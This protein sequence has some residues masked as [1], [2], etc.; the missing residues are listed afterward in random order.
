MTMAEVLERAHVAVRER[1]RLLIGVVNAAKVVKM[2]KDELL[3]GSLLE[4]DVLL[5]DGQ[6]VVWASR[7]LGHPLPERIAGIDLFERLLESANV[8]S[9]SVYFLGARPE[10]LGALLDQVGT[11]F[12]G[13]RVAGSRDGYFSAEESSEVAEMIAA[14]KADML[15]LGIT[16]PKKEIFLARFGDDLNV[17]LM[18]GVGGSFD[19]LAGVTHRAPRA[20]QRL[21]VEWAYRL[22]QEPRRLFKRYLSTNTAFIALTLRERIHPTASYTTASVTRQAPLAPGRLASPAHRKSEEPSD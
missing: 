21:G 11:R 15:F 5:A 17:P 14:S 1:R 3:R 10:V 9:E 8:N 19:I 18:H 13:L 4:T 2:R 22:L 16:S 20:W 7:I 6:S 12:P